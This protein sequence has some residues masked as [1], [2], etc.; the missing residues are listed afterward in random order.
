MS[1]VRKGFSPDG[2]EMDGWE[3]ACQT[4]AN[5][6][7]KKSEADQLVSQDEIFQES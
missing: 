7:R 4:A 3:T 2:W 6:I 5:T 1:W